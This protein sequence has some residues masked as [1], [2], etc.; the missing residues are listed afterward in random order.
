G[1][2][3]PLMILANWRG[4]SGGRKD[5][6]EEVLKF[7]SYIVEHLTEF[8]QPVFVY[9]PPHAEVR[10]G[11]WVV[12]DPM[13]NPRVM[14]MYADESARGGVLEPAGI[15][16]IKFRRAELVKAMHRLD[17]QLQWMKMNAAP[18]VVTKEDIAA[19]EAD[20]MPAYAPLGEVFADLH[21][22]PQRMLA[23]GVIRKVVPWRDS[24]RHFYWR[25]KRRLAEMPL[26][27]RAEASA[28]AL[29]PSEVHGVVAR[30]LVSTAGLSPSELDDDRTVALCLEKLR[31]GE[32][33]MRAVDELAHAAQQARN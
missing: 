14:E 32:E 13:I 15:A 24:R 17:P 3:L 28:P 19:H 11:A 16:E 6:F 23:K 33:L 21:D 10:G 7:G 8:E 9:V 30:A 25:L 5:M 2:R 1:E 27:R 31:Q 22:R 4:F 18:G 29:P 20:L 26:Q 12:I